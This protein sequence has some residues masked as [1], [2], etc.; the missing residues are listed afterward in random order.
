MSYIRIGFE[1]SEQNYISIDNNIYNIRIDNDNNRIINIFNSY[2]ESLK[3]YF[4][5]NKR[6]LIFSPS[7][8]DNF[9]ASG[10]ISFP[11]A[12][13]I[14]HAFLYKLFDLTGYIFAQVIFVAIS[15]YIIFY[16]LKKQYDRFIVLEIFGCFGDIVIS[17]K[18][19]SLKYFE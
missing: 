12:S 6:G 3:G 11:Y 2:Y 10:S 9:E 15:Y 1:I 18:E 7:F 16:F 17:T 5:R 13:I 14:Y 8:N 19:H 4:P